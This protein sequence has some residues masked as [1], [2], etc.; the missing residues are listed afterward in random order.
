VLYLEYQITPMKIKLP[1]LFLSF[2]LFTFLGVA[3]EEGESK[4]HRIAPLVGYVFVPEDVDNKDGSNVRIVPTFGLD[5]DFRLAP[6][7]AIGL[8]N[9]IELNSYFISYQGGELLQREH[10][11]I[12]TLCVIFSAAEGWSVY[13][14]GGYEFEKHH[15]FAVLRLGTEYEIPIRNDWDVA[16]GLSFDHKEVY[17]SIGFTIAFGKRF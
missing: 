8:Y 14:G 10:V 9:D 13:A 6:R 5:Y 2:L 4:R 17:N 11:F 7:W 16:F 12:S 1:L 3:Q 15:N